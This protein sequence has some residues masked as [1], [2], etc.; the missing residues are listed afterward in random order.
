MFNKVSY[1]QG[2]VE[3]VVIYTLGRLGALITPTLFPDWLYVALPLVFLALQYL[4]A[5]VWATYRIQST[6]R[7]RLSKRF[8]L[9]GP[10]LAAICFGIDVLVTLTLGMALSLGEVQQGPAVL[11]L[12]ASGTQHLSLANL[13][14]YELKSVSLLFA[15]FII[16]VICTRLAQGGFLRFT[17]PAGGNRVTL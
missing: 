15:F 12:F 9:L 11:R 14:V 10:L 13:G 6:K 7:E 1:R 17:M 16:A 3:G 8:W 2:I 5:P 4:I